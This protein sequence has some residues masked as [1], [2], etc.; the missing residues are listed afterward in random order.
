MINGISE[1]GPSVSHKVKTVRS[2]DGTS[3]KILDKLD[4]IIKEK[5]DDLIIHV[6]KNHIMDNINILAHVKKIFKEIS[7]E[8][9][10]TFIAF[11]SIIN[12]KDK[13]KIHKNLPD[14]NVRLKNLCM[15]KGVS[16]ID[17]SRINPFVPNASFLYPLKT[18]ENPNFSDIFR[19]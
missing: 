1:K 16:F 7:K 2:P 13:K 5:P 9:P 19:G 10:S 11:S 6:G 15:Q 8:S 4:D 3:E 17:N 14:T 18:S 12:R